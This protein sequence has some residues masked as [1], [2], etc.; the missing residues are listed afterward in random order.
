MIT[1]PEACSCG[2]HPRAQ[3]VLWIEDHKVFHVICYECG[4]EWVE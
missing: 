4:R 2:Y 1:K 3:D